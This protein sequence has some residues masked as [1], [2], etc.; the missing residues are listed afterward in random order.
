MSVTYQGS[1]LTITGLFHPVPVATVTTLLAPIAPCGWVG[2]AMSFGAANDLVAVGYQK[3]LIKT[4]GYTDTFRGTVD[5]YQTDALGTIANIAD[6]IAFNNLVITGGSSSGTANNF[7]PLSISFSPD[8]SYLAIY[9]YHATQKNPSTNSAPFSRLI[10]YQRS[11]NALT[12]VGY[13]DCQ[14][15]PNVS[16]KDDSSSFFIF[17]S[18]NN[19]RWV[20]NVA[21]LSTASDYNYTNGIKRVT[22][23]IPNSLTSATWL[24]NY[25][26]IGYYDSVSN[27]P[28]FRLYLK[29]TNATSGAPSMSLERDNIVLD[30]EMTHPRNLVGSSNRLIV[31]NYGSTGKM[32]YDFSFSAGT[33]TAKAGPSVLATPYLSN[34]FTYSTVKKRLIMGNTLETRIFD[35]KSGT[36]TTVSSSK[37]TAKDSIKGAVQH[38]VS[39]NLIV[40]GNYGISTY[41]IPTAGYAP[42]AA[43][44]PANSLVFSWDF[45]SA[46]GTPATSTSLAP[47]VQTSRDSQTIIKKGNPTFAAAPGKTGKTAMYFGTAGSDVIAYPK[48]QDFEFMYSGYTIEFFIYAQAVTGSGIVF[49]DQGNFSFYNSGV[50]FNFIMKSA[51]NGYGVLAFPSLSLNT[52]HHIVI[53]YSGSTTPP[54]VSSPLSQIK[55]WFNGISSGSS[56]IYVSGTTSTPIYP[57]NYGFGYLAFGAAVDY[58]NAGT[59]ASGAGGFKGYLKGFKMYNFA[60]TYSS[61]FTV[62]TF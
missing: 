24:G 2:D 61:S 36:L 17:S 62:P 41:S 51:R 5:I 27:L 43:V 18:I 28:K 59:P 20:Y 3:S 26:L 40:S 29:G 44:Q 12:E 38:S 49:A 46:A 37:I 16:W 32:V 6:S 10:V 54:V 45:S 39:G 48:G 4:A 35:D 31:G 7:L 58:V 30:S 23:L 14:G 52:W 53:T 50:G 1:F 34:Y 11:A 33:F 15:E 42:I 25:L 22:L 55:G 9:W 56:S 60:Q 8:A 13:I 47:T 57:N 19:E 21:T